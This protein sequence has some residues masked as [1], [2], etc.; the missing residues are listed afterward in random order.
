[1]AT[2]WMEWVNIWTVWKKFQNLQLVTKARETIHFI[3]YGPIQKILMAQLLIWR[4]S[5][6]QWSKFTISRF[7]GVA[8]VENGQAGNSGGGGY[9]NGGNTGGGGREGELLANISQQLQSGQLT[10]IPFHFLLQFS[11]ITDR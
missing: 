8:A 1:M 2:K 3:F 7:E 11:I 6:S 4:N 5:I 10:L 9:L